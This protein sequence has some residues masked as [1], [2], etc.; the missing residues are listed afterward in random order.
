MF[1]LRFYK[2]FFIANQPVQS[3][4]LLTSLTLL[5]TCMSVRR[6]KGMRF[7]LLQTLLRNALSALRTNT[8]WHTL[9]TA[10]QCR[11]AFE[12]SLFCTLQYTVWCTKFTSCTQAAWCFLKIWLK[13]FHTYGTS[14]II[15]SPH[16]KQPCSTR[17][18][19][20]SHYTRQHSILLYTLQEYFPYR[21]HVFVW[22]T[23]YKKLKFNSTHTPCGCITNIFRLKMQREEN[24]W[25]PKYNVHVNEMCNGQAF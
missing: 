8:V 7:P 6:V 3:T 4:W 21:K 2:F 16:N 10:P 14:C 23:L 11:N 5:W 24:H 15:K 25:N 1:T 12:W 13:S 22:N 9:M 17:R 19:L 20:S 18:G